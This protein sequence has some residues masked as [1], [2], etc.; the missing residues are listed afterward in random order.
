MRQ[1]KVPFDLSVVLAGFMAVQSVLG[2]VFPEQY[3][4]VEWIRATWFGNDCPYAYEQHQC[5]PDTQQ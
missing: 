4:D 1:M 2:L 3:R 5:D